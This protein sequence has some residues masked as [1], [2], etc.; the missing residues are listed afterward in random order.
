MTHDWKATDEQ[1]EGVINR[2]VSF[3]SDEIQELIDELECP[4]SF[5]A[6]LLRAIA[7]NIEVNPTEKT[8]KEEKGNTQ[9]STYSSRHSTTP[10]HEKSAQ[11]IVLQNER[12]VRETMKTEKSS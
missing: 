11:Q 5:G 12:I 9:T 8:L 7:D 1:N 3:I 4:K 6:D 2:T 10:E